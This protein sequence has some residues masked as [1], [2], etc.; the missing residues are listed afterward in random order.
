MQG[1]SSNVSNDAC[2]QKIE[3]HCFDLGVTDAS[4]NELQKS[5]YKDDLGKALQINFSLGGWNH[6]I[7]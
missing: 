5:V 3:C 2:S 7:A 6:F 4:F 1:R